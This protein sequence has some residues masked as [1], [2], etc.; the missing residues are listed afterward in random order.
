[1]KRADLGA[2]FRYDG[3]L[4]EVVAMHTEGRMLLLRPV[5]PTACPSCGSTGDIH[6]VEHSP[7]FQDN[8]EPISTLTDKGTEAGEGR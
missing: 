8:A 7:L 2:I 1:M 5:N 6:V 4:V 3:K